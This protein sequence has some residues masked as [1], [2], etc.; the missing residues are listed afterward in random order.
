MELVPTPT[1]SK[2]EMQTKVTLPNPRDTETTYPFQWLLFRPQAH[3][4]EPFTTNV[5]TRNENTQRG[6]VGGNLVGR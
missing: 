5:A 1:Y 2:Q 6:P 3:A 4:V